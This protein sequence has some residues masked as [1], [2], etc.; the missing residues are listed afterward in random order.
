MILKKKKKKLPSPSSCATQGHVPKLLLVLF[1]QSS[2][3]N[4]RQLGENL[5]LKDKLTGTGSIPFMDSQFRLNTLVACLHGHIQGYGGYLGIS[6]IS[7]A[8]LLT[9][10]KVTY[11]YINQLKFSYYVNKRATL[12]GTETCYS[13][14]SEGKAEVP[15]MSC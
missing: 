2:N 12:T 1:N 3:I 7:Q 13:A 14:V 6:S 10:L 11:V 15:M 4:N 5:E 9:P 8:F